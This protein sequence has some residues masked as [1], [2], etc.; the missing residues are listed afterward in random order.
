MPS[1]SDAS[2]CSFLSCSLE[3]VDPGFKFFKISSC[4][5]IGIAAFKLK[6]CSFCSFMSLDLA[7]VGSVVISS[8]FTFV[9]VSCSQF[10]GL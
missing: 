2:D 10:S 6:V 1:A 7:C 9:V 8:G 4:F 3:I 5:V